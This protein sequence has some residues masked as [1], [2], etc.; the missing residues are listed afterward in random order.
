L[1]ITPSNL[2]FDVWPKGEVAT[3]LAGNLVSMGK[4]QNSSFK[5]TKKV[6]A[7]KDIHELKEV[8]SKII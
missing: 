4:N 8:L 1:G 5:L 3:G 2:V 6:S 7:L